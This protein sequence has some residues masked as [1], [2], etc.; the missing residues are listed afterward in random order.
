MSWCGHTKTGSWKPAEYTA[1]HTGDWTTHLWQS[2]AIHWQLRIQPQFCGT[3]HQHTGIVRIWIQYSA[4]DLD[5]EHDYSLQV[6]TGYSE[7][8]TLQHAGQWHALCDQGLSQL[9]HGD[10]HC[11]RTHCLELA[12]RRTEKRYRRDFQPVVKNIVVQS[13]LVCPAHYRYI[14]RC[15]M[16][17][18]F[19]ITLHDCQLCAHSSFM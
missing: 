13:V 7:C 16:L 17:I 10:L 18:D 11:C 12:S 14:I 9:L 4:I 6:T 8:W 2:P 5:I 3:Q 19:Y 1:A 15:A